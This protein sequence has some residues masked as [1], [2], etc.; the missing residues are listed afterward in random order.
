MRRP[1]AVLRRPIRSDVEGA[2]GS[3]GT[4]LLLVAVIAMISVIGVYVFTLVRMPEEPPDIKVSFHQLNDRW[5]ASIT[6]SGQKVPLKEIRLIVRDQYRE[7]VTY[8]SDGDGLKDAV[9]VDLAS[10]LAVSSGDGP[11]TTPLV[12]VDADG[13]GNLTVGDSIVVYEFYY[14]P[15]GP[16]MDADRGYAMVG[17]N[18]NAIP[19]DST[20]RM[21]ASPVTLGNPDIDPG[22]T[23]RI[24]IKQ[25]AAPVTMFQGPASSSGTYVEDWHVPLALSTGNY[26]AIFTI[27]PGEI[28][29]WSQTRSFRVANEAAIT[30]ADAAMYHNTTHP[31]SVGDIVQM[32]HVPSNA[33]SLEFRL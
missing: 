2:A 13:D 28:D 21:V 32:V 20:L 29:E 6:Y 18:P 16:L 22:D 10:N 24:E 7:Y 11:Q 5:S 12:Y 31:F 9:L 19:R 33:V 23:V 14:F 17:P 4:S 27:R 3:I 1:G 30:P 15:S 8:D 26:D 25:G